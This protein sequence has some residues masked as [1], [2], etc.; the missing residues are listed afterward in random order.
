MSKSWAGE[1]EIV[2]AFK[3]FDGSDPTP[4]NQAVHEATNA[5]M[6]YAHEYKMVVFEIEKYMKRARANDR[7]KYMYIIDN[8]LQQ[9]KSTSRDNFITRFSGR[10]KQICSQFDDAEENS[11]NVFASVINKWRKQNLFNADVL[12]EDDIAGTGDVAD[13]NFIQNDHSKQQQSSSSNNNSKGHTVSTISHTS[14]FFEIPKNSQKKKSS[15]KII[16]Y[17]TFREGTC[18]LGDKC[19]YSHASAGT[20]Y[21]LTRKFVKRKN[22]YYESFAPEKNKRYE[23]VEKQQN[24]LS[25]KPDVFSS[26][27][28]LPIVKPVLDQD[29]A[30]MNRTSFDRHLF[31]ATSTRSDVQLSWISNEDMEKLQSV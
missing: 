2:K 29:E 24:R 12:P 1:K 19:R 14:I 16:K 23:F 13:G 18:I 7:A 9:T 6:K 26:D 5:C 3:A 20:S 30:N 21:S 8:I 25:S 31:E 17:C 15:Q 10:M 28:Q 22:G 4:H 11:K 27:F